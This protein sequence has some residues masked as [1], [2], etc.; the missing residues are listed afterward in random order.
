MV[1]GVSADERI[2][3]PDPAPVLAALAAALSLRA[4]SSRVFLAPAARS[5]VELVSAFLF[6]GVV[7][8]FSLLFI[9][10]EEGGLGECTCTVDYLVSVLLFAV[11]LY[12]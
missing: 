11:F 3:D 12:Y 10:P 7:S 4:A 9:P 6:C 5:A 1:G 2:P 8:I